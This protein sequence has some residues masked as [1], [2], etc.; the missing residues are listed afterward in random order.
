[1]HNNSTVTSRDSSFISRSALK[2]PPKPK[3]CCQIK[4][5]T[6]K[7]PQTCR[8]KIPAPVLLSHKHARRTPTFIQP[9]T[10]KWTETH[11]LPKTHS[12]NRVGTHTLIQ[13]TT[14]TTEQSPLAPTHLM[15]SQYY[16][17]TD[18]HNCAG[19][20]PCFCWLLSMAS[21]MSLTE[22]IGAA[23]TTNLHHCT[24]KYVVSV[25]SC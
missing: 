25:S 9:N 23:G 12:H 22:V 1:M 13:T 10:Y 20:V 17:K 14:P 11:T 24:H 15:F 3:Q 18:T 2:C 21:A 5:L 7:G 6:T 8:L 4:A 16:V 19:M